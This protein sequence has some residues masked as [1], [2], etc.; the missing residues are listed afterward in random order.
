[1]LNKNP[2]L[3][4]AIHKNAPRWL[5]KQSHPCAQAHGLTG[6]R[7]ICLETASD[8]LCQACT[9]IIL[10]CTVTCFT[11]K[12]KG[13]AAFLELRIIGHRHMRIPQEL[14]FL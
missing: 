13:I 1:M 2:A 9:L 8:F 7:C 4:F 12:C 11:A 14:M 10:L 5:L 3:Y 6:D